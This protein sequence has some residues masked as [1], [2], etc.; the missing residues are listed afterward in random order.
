MYKISSIM[1]S[2]ISF[3]YHKIN[4]KNFNILIL[5]QFYEFITKLFQALDPTELCFMQAH[6]NM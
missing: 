6:S 1:Q 2:I 4:H 5:F 3:L